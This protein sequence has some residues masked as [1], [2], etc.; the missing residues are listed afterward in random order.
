LDL[1]ASGEVVPAS[2]GLVLATVGRPAYGGVDDS[3]FLVADVE[4]AS[5]LGE[6]Q[7]DPSPEWRWRCDR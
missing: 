1:E 2:F 7:A 4:Q 3:F 6:G 5:D